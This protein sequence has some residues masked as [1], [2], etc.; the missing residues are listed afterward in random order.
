MR[1]GAAYPSL[2][3]CLLLSGK[4]NARSQ[5]SKLA[6]EVMIILEAMK[7]GHRRSCGVREHR[8]DGE[9]I[10]KG[11]SGRRECASDPSPVDKL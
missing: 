3:P 6:D 7:N 9:R 2:H 8:K 1:P 5:I 4:S 10:R 11:D